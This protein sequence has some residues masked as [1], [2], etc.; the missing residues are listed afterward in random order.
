MTQ[1]SL[2][3]RGTTYGRTFLW[4][5]CSHWASNSF[6]LHTL[7]TA[8]TSSM[9]GFPGSSE[10]T[11]VMQTAAPTLFASTSQT[12]TRSARRASITA[13][14]ANLLP[15]SRSLA[16]SD[17]LTCNNKFSLKL[18]AHFCSAW[19]SGSNSHRIMVLS[20]S[21]RSMR[22]ATAKS[23]ASH[24]RMPTWKRKDPLGDRPGAA[25]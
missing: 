5:A 21:S 11:R 2:Q 7:Y 13:A 25:G 24:G 16:G 19:M 8:Y 4:S 22:M 18:F 14:A 20:M 1:S 3:Y 9:H 6:S 17:S 10:S 15:L 12:T 23:A